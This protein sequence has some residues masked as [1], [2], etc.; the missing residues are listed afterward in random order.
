MTDTASSL[1]ITILSD[2]YA[3]YEQA[4]TAY[5]DP[6]FTIACATDDPAQ[7]ATDEVQVMLA[8]PGLAAAVINDC[9]QLRWLQSGWAG[10]TPL[11]NAAKRDYVLTGVKGVFGRQMREYVFAYLLHFSRNV[12]G[13]AAAQQRPDSPKWQAPPYQYL[14]GTTLGIVGAGSIAGSLL[15][16]ADALGMQVIGL[17]Q[18]GKATPGYQAMYSAAQKVEFAEQCDYMVNLLPDTPA[19]RHLIDGNMLR[20]LGSQGV[21]IN[22]GRG[23]AVVQDEL[24]AVL[25][26]GQLRAAVLD[27]FEQEPLPD[28]HPFWQHPRILVTQHT[29]AASDPADIAELMH[30][31]AKRYLAGAPLEHVFNFEKGY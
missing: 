30:H 19:T 21:F 23:N 11:V 28:I 1:T 31:N 29:A 15:P 17:R 22:A 3:Q 5:T 14:A 13:F 10:N 18:S 9:H 12:A 26:A 16:V 7:V 4:L 8:D 25:D 6:G 2:E 20:A 27:V 24:L